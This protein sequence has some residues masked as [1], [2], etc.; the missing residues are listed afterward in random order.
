MRT[1]MHRGRRGP[2]SVDDGFTL[3]EV[4]VSLVLLSLIFTAVTTLFI[5]SLRSADGLQDKQAAVP[6]STQGLDLARSIPAIRDAAGNSELVAGRTQAAVSAQWAAV[7]GLDGVDLTDTYATWDTTATS[8]STPTLPLSTT[9]LVSGQSYNVQSSW[10]S[11]TARRWTA[12]AS[13]WVVQHA[14]CHGSRRPGAPLSRDRDRDVHRGEQRGLRRR[15]HVR[16]VDADRPLLGPDVQHERQDGASASVAVGDSV[17]STP[18]AP[19]PPP[20]STC[21]ATTAGPSRRIPSSSG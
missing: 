13:S 11:A 3:I 19:E 21:W 2:L 12:T 10:V 17:T 16:H 5:R 8:A 4:V 20:S 6:V 15:V 1:S 18:R 14:S 7:A 9:V